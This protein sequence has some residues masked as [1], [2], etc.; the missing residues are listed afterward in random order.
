MV[1]VGLVYLLGSFWLILE[2]GMFLEV[3]FVVGMLLED[4]L[5]VLI[6]WAGGML[7]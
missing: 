2:R 5:V 6:F 7:G 1:F 4:F 3:F